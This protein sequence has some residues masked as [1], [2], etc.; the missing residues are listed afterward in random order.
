MQL[1]SGQSAC[2]LVFAL[3]VEAIADA[4]DGH[5]VP[6]PRGVRF[7]FATQ[8]EHVRVDSTRDHG[9][10]IAPHRL[11]QLEP[12]AHLAAMTQQLEQQV[13]FLGT[14]RDFNAGFAHPAC[15]RIDFDIAEMQELRSSLTSGLAPRAP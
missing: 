11:H 12:G 10:R 1:F 14:E 13:V 6:R 7:E 5:Y 3:V 2:W 15:A 9:R 8:F 4:A